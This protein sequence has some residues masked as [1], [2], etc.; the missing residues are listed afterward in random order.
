MPRSIERALIPLL[1]EHRDACINIAE[2][3]GAVP[4]R[5]RFRAAVYPS[6]NDVDFGSCRR[7]RN[8][9]LIEGA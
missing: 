9:V 7:P 1:F 3:V 8:A 5:V 2:L 6:A 4:V